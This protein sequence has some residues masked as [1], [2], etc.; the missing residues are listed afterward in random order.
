[1]ESIEDEQKRRIKNRSIVAK[2]SSKDR[3]EESRTD[4]L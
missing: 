1:M 3:K 2:A 4:Q